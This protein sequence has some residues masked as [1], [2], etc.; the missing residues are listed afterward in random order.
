MVLV[1]TVT[2]KGM[3]MQD[4]D[5]DSDGAM[6]GDDS[7]EEAKTIGKAGNGARWWKLAMMAVMKRADGDD[8]VRR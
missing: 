8:D 7:G 6:D 4:G 3:V 2:V 1:W 5:D